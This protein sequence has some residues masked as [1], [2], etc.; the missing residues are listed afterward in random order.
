MVFDTGLPATA[1]GRHRGAGMAP[2]WAAATT[3]PASIILCSATV[4]LSD[5][6][7]ANGLITAM[8]RSRSVRTTCSPR[9]T[10]FMVRENRG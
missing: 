2:G 4:S 9:R 1:T 8:G 10:T 5:A 3:S 6:L 7:S